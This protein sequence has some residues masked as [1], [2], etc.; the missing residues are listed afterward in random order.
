MGKKITGYILIGVGAIGYAFFEQYRGQ[1]FPLPTLWF[2]L[3]II[4]IIA[5]LLMILPK[6]R[7]EKD[8]ISKE[9]ARIAKLKETG[10]KIRLNIDDCDFKTQ[11]YQEEIDY[12]LDRVKMWD[13][14]SPPLHPVE[15]KDINQVVIV[16]DHKS[17]SKEEKFISQVFP[18]DVI[19]LQYHIMNNN[20]TLYVDRFDR[21]SYYFELE[22][23][24]K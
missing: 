14:V 7:K 23:S 13:A 15:I 18:M 1:L 8:I 9:N 17:G 11:N 3:S 21:R 2:S 24:F 5:G 4:I 12:R 16:Y 22:K 6:T 10:E 20:L 19:T